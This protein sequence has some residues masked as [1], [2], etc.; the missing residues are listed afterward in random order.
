MSL[1]LSRRTVI[2][3][4]IATPATADGIGGGDLTESQNGSG[5]NGESIGLWSGFGRLVVPE[6]T[7]RVHTSGYSTV[8]LGAATYFAT[9]STA[10]T[11]WRK[12]S[13]NGR[14]FELGGSSLTPEQVGA[15]GDGIKDDSEALVVALS[16]GR[17]VR[18]RRGAKYRIA[19][20]VYVEDHNIGLDLSGS[21]LIDDTENGQ[22]LHLHASPIKIVAVHSIGNTLYSGSVYS[23]L[24]VSDDS[25]VVVGDVLKI[26]SDD[27]ITT[28]ADERMGEFAEV[29]SSS[30]G[31]IVLSSTLLLPMATNIRCAVMNR[32]L[33]CEV[34]GLTFDTS[35]SDDV[36]RGFPYCL[37]VEGYIRPLV[38]DVHGKRA[39]GILVMTQSCYRTTGVRISA[40]YL[41]DAV[42]RGGFGYGVVD[43]GSQYSIWRELDFDNVRH[44]YTTGANEATV[45][46]TNP[47]LYGGAVRCRVESGRCVN[48]TNYA[49]DT[50]EDAW[51]CSFGDV[52]ANGARRV[53]AAHGGGAQD[54]GTGTVYDRLTVHGGD[55]EQLARNG[56]AMNV[57]CNTHI[58]EFNY[59][60][61][62]TALNCFA[63]AASTLR[64][65][66]MNIT[67]SK[68][69]PLALWSS[70][71][72]TVDI[73]EMHIRV[74]KRPEAVMLTREARLF[75]LNGGNLS[76]DNL[77]W[78]FQGLPSGRVTGAPTLVWLEAETGDIAISRN[79]LKLDDN[80][81][82]MLKTV[83]FNGGGSDG[84]D[85][86]FA[87]F[88]C[89]TLIRYP[90]FKRLP[91]SGGTYV[92][93]YIV[94]AS[95]GPVLHAFDVESRADQLSFSQTS[96]AIMLNRSNPNNV[97][98]FSPNRFPWRLQQFPL[99]YRHISKQIECHA[100]AARI[101]AIPPPTFE[102]Q[103]LTITAS[104]HSD[105]VPTLYD[106][107]ILLNA[108]GVR[109][110][111]DLVIAQGA[112]AEFVGVFYSG[113]LRWEPF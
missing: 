77:T 48:P 101:N 2:A 72:A 30:G 3:G 17:P 80:T 40:D 103:R 32:A 36:T 21:I 92:F 81:A 62:G 47:Y 86:G 53:G 88:R 108:A 59:S 24:H 58:R 74:A 6:G 38:S 96:Q 64:V 113:T 95:G 107:V 13:A 16:S 42:E 51:E 18:G 65:D 28:K 112:R 34:K 110:T 105:V 84:V 91:S 75:R 29:V 37:N 66:V 55:D 41:R 49:W 82:A 44:A 39:L 11:P 7:D 63:S 71:T 78:H 46:N 9:T 33:T 52:E 94:N 15:V 87:H 56:F 89:E 79:L 10:A 104:R 20:K 60:G 106:V 31:S 57:Q 12:Q 70:P 90:A 61:G 5:T 19:K 27:L 14:W 1:G 23:V 111:S 35:V 93:D 83:I 85:R 102:G 43:Y 50:H 25:G 100:S 54:R 76:V 45:A 8:G 97:V 109:L 69:L 67:L 68:S 22:C 4:S 99:V 98:Y 73:G 26:Y